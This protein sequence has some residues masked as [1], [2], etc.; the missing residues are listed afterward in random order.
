L[1]PAGDLPLDATTQ[2][3]AF[4][5]PEAGLACIPADSPRSDAAGRCLAEWSVMSNSHSSASFSTLELDELT[6]ITGGAGAQ[7]SQAELRQLAQQYCP[8]TYSKFSANRTITRPM[9]ERC[10]DEAGLGM[11]KSRL[12]AYFPRK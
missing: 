4:L 10:L 5:F 9:G 11:F 7:K 2:V 3:V 6:G 8:A 12:D 1:L